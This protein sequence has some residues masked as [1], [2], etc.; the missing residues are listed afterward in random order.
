MA[1]GC[2]QP[3]GPIPTRTAD[4]QNEVGDVSRDILALAGGDASAA[5][6][7]AQD[8]AT[9][10]PHET[11]RAAAPDMARR[12]QAA[13]RGRSVSEQQAMRLADQMYL[14]FGADKLSGRQ[15][16]EI[17]QNVRALLTEVGAP[18]E[19]IEPAVEQVATAQALVNT[20]PRRWWQLR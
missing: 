8:L 5:E 1:T 16:T 6:D 19:T 18:A 15:V 17:Q 20:A 9:L 2:R 13:L 11:G 4:E 7:L 14:T 10:G 12:L 3:D